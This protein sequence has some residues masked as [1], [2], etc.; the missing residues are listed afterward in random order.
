MTDP[1]KMY[2]GEEYER[3]VEEIVKPREW[4]MIHLKD[5]QR[6][7]CQILGPVT[8]KNN[9]P[10]RWVKVI[11]KSAWD[12]RD[13]EAKHFCRLYNEALDEILK[14]KKQLGEEPGDY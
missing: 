5:S 8:S 12:K 11:E 13:R 2:E 7:Y 1:H 6:E 14:L 3:Q 10:M 4:E 9:E